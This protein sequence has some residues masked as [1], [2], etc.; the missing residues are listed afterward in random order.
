MYIFCQRHI[1]QSSRWQQKNETVHNSFSWYFFMN[2]CFATRNSGFQSETLHTGL[3]ASPSTFMLHLS[4]KCVTHT[5]MMNSLLLEKKR[6]RVWGLPWQK[7]MWKEPS[8]TF[9][10]LSNKC[11]L[12]QFHMDNCDSSDGCIEIHCDV[13]SET[14]ESCRI[15]VHKRKMQ[16]TR[17]DA[18]NKFLRTCLLST[19]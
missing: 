16:R 18:R 1:I 13:A 7:K 6:V 4:G 3:L 5:Q 19:W 14:P 8:I 12:W 17:G 15:P 10:D 11:E 2:N 9:R